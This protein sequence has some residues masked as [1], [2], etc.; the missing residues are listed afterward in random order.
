MDHSLRGYLER[1]TTE[2]LRQMLAYYTDEESELCRL[3]AQMI[4]EILQKR[5]DT[6]C[7]K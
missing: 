3:T 5:N 4:R 7:N 6:P 2:E 1:R